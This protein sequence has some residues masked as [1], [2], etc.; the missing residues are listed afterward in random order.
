MKRLLLCVLMIVM[1]FTMTPLAAFAEDPAGPE[2]SLPPVSVENSSGESL[3]TLQKMN[4]T[5]ENTHTSYGGTVP[6]FYKLIV[7]AGTSGNLTF[8]SNDGEEY[9]FA[10]SD[11]GKSK[12]TVKNT[13]SKNKEDI[14]PKEN[15]NGSSVQYTYSV[16]YEETEEFKPGFGNSK[17]YIQLKNEDGGHISL[18]EAGL[19]TRRYI[20][21]LE[22]GKK[23]D[24]RKKKAVFGLFVQFGEDQNITDTDLPKPLRVQDEGDVIYPAEITDFEGVTRYKIDKYGVESV[25]TVQDRIYKVVVPDDVNTLRFDAPNSIQSVGDAGF[26]KQNIWSGTVE[27]SKDDLLTGY[28]AIPKTYSDENPEEGQSLA[29]LYGMDTSK[30]IAY[31]NFYNITYG[32]AMKSLVDSD[33]ARRP[34]PSFG[35]LIQFG[36]EIPNSGDAELQVT[37]TDIKLNGS[38]K[39]LRIGEEADINVTL[40][41]R[42]EKPVSD[43]EVRLIQP[44]AN[45]DTTVYVTEEMQP[46]ESRE[47]PFKFTPQRAK[48]KANSGKTTLKVLVNGKENPESVTKTFVY[49]K[50]KVRLECTGDAE[51]GE[52]MTV[53][54]IKSL[55]GQYDEDG[56]YQQRFTPNA[57]DYLVSMDENTAVYEFVGD[58]GFSWGIDFQ[59]PDGKCLQT[60]TYD[61]GTTATYTNEQKLRIVFDKE[62]QGKAYF[63]DIRATE[64]RKRFFLGISEKIYGNEVN[65]EEFI[66]GESYVIQLIWKT[67]DTASQKLYTMNVYE[68]ERLVGSQ[69][70]IMGRGSV[71]MN[72]M[73]T[74]GEK[75]YKPRVGATTLVFTI[76]HG[77]AEVARETV[78][79]QVVP[80]NKKKLQSFDIPMQRA[81]DGFVG[82]QIKRVICL[83][84]GEKNQFLAVSANPLYYAGNGIW[85]PLDAKGGKGLLNLTGGYDTNGKIDLTTLKAVDSYGILYHFNGKKWEKEQDSNYKKVG[86]NSLKQVIFVGNKIVGLEISG[87]RGGKLYVGEQN[88][89]TNTIE[90]KQEE[91]LGDNCYSILLGGDGKVYVTT[92]TGELHQYDGTAWKKLR[93]ETTQPARVLA[94]ESEDEIW[95]AEKF[96]EESNVK[97][98]IQKYGYKENGLVP[99]QTCTTP[100]GIADLPTGFIKDE[101]TMYCVYNGSLWESEDDGEKWTRQIIDS[102]GYERDTLE[103]IQKTEYGNFY[104]GSKGSFYYDGTALGE[105]AKPANEYNARTVRVAV[106]SGD[107]SKKN[108]AFG[109]KVTV[110]NQFDLTPYLTY[111]RYGGGGDGKIPTAAD[112]VWGKYSKEDGTGFKV[113]TAMH[114]VVKMLLEQGCDFSSTEKYNYQGKEYT[115]PAILDAQANMGGGVYVAM[116]NGLRE[117]DEGDMSGWMYLVNGAYPNLGLSQWALDDGD[118]IVLRY[119]TRYAGGSESRGSG[120]RL[121]T[122]E[123]GQQAEIEIDPGTTLTFHS[124]VGSSYNDADMAFLYVDGRRYYN[125]TE[126]GA[127]ETAMTDDDGLLQMTFDKDG[128][129]EIYC[130]KKGI[131]AQSNIITVR[132]GKGNV[133][134]EI[135]LKAAASR[136]IPNQEVLL[137]V[138][139]LEGNAMPDIQLYN[140]A[141]DEELNGIVTDAS[142]QAKVSFAEKG[143]YQ[144][145]AKGEETKASQAI[146]LTIAA[147]IGD[148]QTAMSDALD[149]A[150]TRADRLTGKTPWNGIALDR[151]AR[152]SWQSGTLNELVQEI[153]SS[154]E[155]NSG[156]QYEL[157]TDYAK[158]VLA[159]QAAGGDPSSLVYNKTKINLLEKIYNFHVRLNDGT[160]KNLYAQ[161]LNA[162]IWSLI[163]LDSVPETVPQDARY[164]KADLV[165]YIVKAQNADGSF[166]LIRGSKG[167]VDITAMALQALAKHRNENG[168]EAAVQKAVQWLAAQQKE[169]GGFASYYSNDNCE[170]TAQTIIALTALRIDSAATPFRTEPGTTMLDALLYYHLGDG[171]FAHEANTY[172]VLTANDLASEQAHLALTA[173]DRYAQNKET[174]YDMSGTERVDRYAP[175]ITTDLRNYTTNEESLN[176]TV[177]AEDA[178]DGNNIE[179]TVGYKYNEDSAYKQTNPDENGRY[180]V[181]LKTFDF[182]AKT[183]VFFRITATDK[184]GN[185]AVE[186]YV[187]TYSKD[188][189][190]KTIRLPKSVQTV[191]V[192]KTLTL[193]AE[194]TPDNA[195]NKTL[196]WTSSDT[197]VATVDENGNV[198]ALRSGTVTIT[199]RTCDGSNLAA[200]CKVLC[201]LPQSQQPDDKTIKVTFTLLGDTVH[202]DKKPFHTLREN[203]L[204]T[205]IAP[206]TV[207]VEKGS[208][209]GDVFAQILTKHGYTFEGLSK[210][211]I[212]HITT[213]NGER[214]GEFTNGNLSGWMYT[215]NGHHPEVGLNSYILTGGDRIIWHYTDDY[216]VEEGSEKWNKQNDEVKDVTTSGSSGSATTKAPTE[217]KVSGNTAA[218]KVK[219]E[220]SA[221]IIKQAKENKSFEII[222]E[223][224]AGNTKGAESVQMQLDTAFVKDIVEKTNADLTVNTENGRV[225]F[226]QEALKAII[227]EAKGNTILIE[228]AKVTK[229]TEAQKKAASTN[230]DIFS[231]LVKSGD[232]NISEFNKGKA[233]VRVEIPAKLADKKV[234]AIY[235]AADAKI[236]Q[237]AGKILTIGGK[238]YYEFTTPHFSTFALVDAEELGLEVEEPQVDAKALTA[239]LTPVARSAKTA[240]KNVKVT[241]SLDKQDKTMIKELKDAGYTVKYRFCR[242]TKKAAGYKAAVTKKTAS[243]TNTSG[244]KGTK[245]F[246]KVQV[247][248]YDENGKLTAKTA[249]KQCKYASR[250]WAKAN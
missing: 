178:K 225:S 176:F 140:A 22:F 160:V 66:E 200:E 19:D 183:K 90:W 142:G 12:N 129:Y 188:P 95:V 6:I 81:V 239:K 52:R 51:S 64:M 243:Y 151:Q 181:R 79:I 144:I 241:V 139:D 21:Y 45:G 50:F 1:T 114:A 198:T 68:D 205:W 99:I 76:S 170:S 167:D 103:T 58:Y 24:Y 31:V 91:R 189:V 159:I 85:E 48:N 223:V 63:E 43:F 38:T 115:I 36:G 5:G 226:D 16:R 109:G 155:A 18:E 214:I 215:V 230:G 242:S 69:S 171:S 168:V 149:L 88:T 224:S 62:R 206:V 180:N 105:T 119:V 130:Y 145:Y 227:S 104:L 136:S 148:I 228:I 141:N 44:D 25:V 124:E 30:N 137:T 249:L 72:P 197:K 191:E 237:L 146:S 41:N 94:A 61:D 116:V 17:F 26:N 39:A 93:S 177:L 47:I 125:Y 192:G 71:G 165:R 164:R 7:P 199:A 87:N 89:K 179:L 211:Y 117:F 28:A 70:I 73:L 244:K 157:V 120:T 14:G 169:N 15:G 204:K 138:T 97:A 234:A 101:S 13:G 74:L 186:E 161:G 9:Y 113:P 98:K 143:T 150:N 134:P 210:N 166:A 29:E 229:P 92:Y 65:P 250:I 173:Y 8:H 133:K 182:L 232:K 195:K 53:S 32:E 10:S 122:R 20:A 190:V 67:Q 54:A 2:N 246:Y 217:V 80:G 236:E 194:V 247:R 27:L 121:T 55:D 213:P 42:G 172:G 147:E 126:S 135:R 112:A 203:N 35:L 86:T 196:T 233:T 163:A 84:D 174:L 209:V 240:K 33:Y 202:G 212:S 106:N 96:K 235:I 3:G 34:S 158:W 218:A 37:A 111:Y 245:Y 108:F 110:D 187:V 221:E 207:T 77:S 4:V 152:G 184:A 46:G 82:T 216:T 59:M 222:L 156:T 102:D 40:E 154:I 231:L 56:N 219:A 127:K 248:V 193:E 57:E 23:N 49:G 162:P 100:M 153:G 220:H 83:K 11:Y 75:L 132:V 185:T 201:E 208:S 175:V 78:R 131:Y 238:K 107:S 123:Y 118:V 60:F 128:V